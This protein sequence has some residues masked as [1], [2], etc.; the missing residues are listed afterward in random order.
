MAHEGNTKQ[1][2][3]QGDSVVTTIR[4]PREVHERFRQRAAENERSVSG[5]IR[6]LVNRS[7]ADDDEPL[8]AA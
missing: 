4:L 7:L 3:E 2:S 6:L 8:A 5:E 1:T